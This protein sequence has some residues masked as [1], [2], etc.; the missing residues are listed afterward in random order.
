M[1]KRQ[2]LY[3]NREK[4]LLKLHNRQTKYFRITV[5][6]IAIPLFIYFILE[7]LMTIEMI[8]SQ[9]LY[10]GK[11]F[12]PILYDIQYTALITENHLPVLK[13][14]IGVFSLIETSL[15]IIANIILTLPFMMVT[16]LMYLS[17]R[18][19]RKQTSYRYSVIREPLMRHY[20]GIL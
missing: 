2:D 18:K 20:R 19:I 9:M 16:I 5:S 10:Y 11:C 15:V 3:H 7:T 6:F 12:F 13:M 1:E 4:Y 17:Y 8:F 14:V